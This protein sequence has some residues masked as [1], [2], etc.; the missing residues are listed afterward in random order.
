MPTDGGRVVIVGCGVVGAAIAYELSQ[1][2][3]LAITVVDRQPPARAST[4]AALGVLMGVISQKTK[5]R[6][7]NLRQTSLRRYQ[8]WLPE[9]EALTEQPV[10]VNRQGVLLLSFEEDLSKWETLSS[11]RQQQGWP[12]ELW[13][14]AQVGDR[15]PQVS[16]N[17]VTAGIYSPQDYQIDPTALTR[18]LVT[19]AAQRGVQ[20]D[21]SS[22]V[23]SL[24]FVDATGQRC[25]GVRT[26]Q[27]DRLLADWVVI[28]SGLGTTPL[29]DALPLPKIDIRPV[30]GQAMRVKLGEP[31]GDR[32]FQPVITGDD[33][34]I[35]PLGQGEYWIGA[36]VE[37]PESDFST[38]D[39]FSKLEAI[40]A[41][42]AALETVWEGAIAL[43]PELSQAEVLH[44]WSGLRPRPANRPAPVLERLN[45]CPN[46]ILATG[47]YR[48]GV[49]LAPATAEWVKGE[50][51]A[52]IE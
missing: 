47:H 16:L 48:N 38:T 19:G 22:P 11:I 15:C 9:L 18:A 14:P 50:I 10:P 40:A 28:A 20:F 44:T 27:G 46:L 42:P 3:G 29:L 51:L 6:A 34:H 37:F 39:S 24:E 36:T 33:I 21:F 52:G 7:W 5:G 8:Q 4:G 12:L 26:A 49:L 23:A 45:T 25:V 2:N 17:A 13:R 31:M 35:V 41:N 32:T 30:L 43:C 1:V